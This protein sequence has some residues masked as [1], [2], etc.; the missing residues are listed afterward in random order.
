MY[1]WIVSWVGL[2]IVYVLAR[3]VYI[4]YADEAYEPP[5]QSQWFWCLSE[6]EYWLAKPSA[7]D[8]KMQLQL[9][10]EPETGAYVR[11][12]AETH[13]RVYEVRD[14]APSFDA[15]KRVFVAQRWWHRE[16]ATL[17][18]RIAFACV[19]GA[20]ACF[21]MPLV[22]AAVVG[23]VTYRL[24]LKVID[25]VPYA[26]GALLLACGISIAQYEE[27]VLLPVWIGVV[28]LF[29]TDN[30]VP[31][32]THAAVPVAFVLAVA[33]DTWVFYLFGMVLLI[34]GAQRIVSFDAGDCAMLD[35]PRR[36]RP[37]VA[38]LVFV[39]LKAV[40]MAF[41]LA[42]CTPHAIVERPAEVPAIDVQPCDYN[43]L[44]EYQV[45]GG[46]D[47]MRTSCF[48]SPFKVPCPL[49]ANPFTGEQL[50]C[51]G[52]GDCFLSADLKTS[53]CY[54]KSNKMGNDM[55]GDVAFV[56]NVWTDG[57]GGYAYMACNEVNAPCAKGGGAPPSQPEGVYISATPAYPSGQERA[58]KAG[59]LD[60]ENAC[61]C[62]CSPTH[63][64]PLCDKTC[65][66]VNG[67]CNDDGECV[68][69]VGW[70]GNDC[71]QPVCSGSGTLIN[72]VCVCAGDRTGPQCN[73]SC[74]LGPQGQV[75]SGRGTC[76]DESSTGACVCQPGWDPATNCSTCLSGQCASPIAG[77]GKCSN[78]TCGC[79][80]P[81]RDFEGGCMECINNNFVL[82]TC[83][84]CR[85]GL[86][87]AD[88]T[89]QCTQCYNE[90]PCNQTTGVCNC[91]ATQTTG[92][93]CECVISA[94]AA[95]NGTC[96]EKTGECL[97]PPGFC[98]VENEQ[99]CGAPCDTGGTCDDVTGKCVPGYA[100]ALSA[101][102]AALSCARVPYSLNM[103]LAYRAV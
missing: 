9:H 91:D 8:G 4:E 33:G 28:L 99:I 43:A 98:L 54:C 48:V 65:E 39:L 94:C 97:C 60:A 24:Q 12:S 75:C 67:V 5:G 66:C 36:L 64:G 2:L 16:Q 10:Q 81:L 93:Q 92:P 21:T 58:G 70:S 85:S 50:V 102:S 6:D 53:F 20:A 62:V 68:C 37:H 32:F 17:Y 78:G 89:K 87:G 90:Q 61:G 82:P 49:H 11:L 47:V 72:N 35:N 14:E 15:D 74:P 86:W 29:G 84:S 96:D 52:N 40:A 1:V 7:S 18:V 100:P 76:V 59:N 46:F 22:Y 79:A 95:T 63:F 13:Y 23:A 57:V 41:V 25:P 103:E 80:D 55:C 45:N 42:F 88:C 69:T 38:Q 71:S 51:G 3:G 27:E 26:F 77:V 83:R 31:A 19:T 30:Y 44:G 56:P 73:V 101:A 34:A